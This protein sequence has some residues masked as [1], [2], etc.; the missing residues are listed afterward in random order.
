MGQ[1]TDSVVRS[2]DNGPDGMEPEGVIES[3]W[4]EIVDSF[5]DMNLSESLLRGIYAYGFEKPSAIQQR[6]ILPCIKGYDV[7]AQAQSGTGKTATFAISILQQIELDL[8]ATQALVLA[9]TRELA[10]QIQKVV[11]ALGDYMGASCHA[12]I[13]GT[14][15]RAE[16][17]KLQMEAPHIIVGTPGRVFDMLN[18]RYLSPKYIKM[19]VLDEADEMLSRGFKD[20]I[21]DIFQKL[22]SNTQVVLLSATMPSD[23]LEV[24]KKFMR[25]PIRILVKKEE[26]TLEGIRQFYI[27][28][29]REEWKLDTLCDLYETLTITQAVIFINTRR[30]VDWL[31]EKMHARDFTVSAMHG[32]MDQKERDVIMREFRSGSSRVLITTDLLARGIDVQQV[33]LVINYDLPTNRENYIHRIG[34]GG[35]FGRKGVAINMV[36]EEDKRT[37]RDIETFYNTSIEEMPLNVADLI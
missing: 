23:V 31:T 17:Q 34:R 6:A 19:F 1:R 24:T 5:D 32:D 29:E 9:P 4:N 13:G 28:V 35:R 18:R 11:M 20:Q 12:C 14:N 10:Q 8:K 3:N 37:L 30:K 15:V 33:S 27:N 7:I 21:Y 25:D 2:R 16:V 26:L 22:N 36:T